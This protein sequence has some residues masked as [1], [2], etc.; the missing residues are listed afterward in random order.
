MGDP[1]IA[2]RAAI[3]MERRQKGRKNKKWSYLSLVE[4]VAD[5]L[6]GMFRDGERVHDSRL[7]LGSIERRAGSRPVAE[8]SRGLHAV[9]R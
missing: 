5:F 7:S 4:G 6:H 9:V 3:L 8:A 2:G 1:A